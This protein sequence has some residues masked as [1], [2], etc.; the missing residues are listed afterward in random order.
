MRCRQLAE[1]LPKAEIIYGDGTDQQLL[2]EIERRKMRDAFASL[3]GFDEENIMM[4]LYVGSLSKAKRITEMTRIPFTK[5]IA[6]SSMWGSVFFP[7]L[8]V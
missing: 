8:I 3:T 2:M 7:V 4:S 5:V 1:L 6:Q